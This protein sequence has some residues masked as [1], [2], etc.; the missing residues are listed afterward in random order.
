MVYTRIRLVVGAL[1]FR[2]RSPATTSSERHAYVARRDEPRTIILT[3]LIVSA[4]FTVA[5][6]IIWSV[7]SLFLLGAGLT[8]FQM[9]IVNTGFTLGDLIFQIPTGV[10]ADTLGRKV[11]FMLSIAT[12][13][14]S[15]LL[16][17]A[18]AQYRWGMGAFI[19]AS[20]FIGL[21]FTFYSGA[22]EAWLVDA[23]DRAR[24][25]RPKEQVFAWG[26]MVF[27]GAMVVGSL[28]GG[29]L[30]QIDLRLPYLVR[31]GA[32]AATFIIVAFLMD[33]SAFVRKALTPSAFAE[34]TRRILGR[35]VRVGWHSK[36]VR[37]LL[38][39]SMVQGFFYIFGFYSWQPYFLSLLGRREVWLVGVLASAFGLAGVLGNLLVKPLTAGGRRDP[40]KVLA[41]VAI[42]QSVTI[43]SIGL[44]G[45]LPGAKGGGWLPFAGA[46]SLYLV[47]GVSFGLIR[48]I[49]QGFV[50]RYIPSDA[51]AT[52][53]SANWLFSDAGES[54][55]Q[56]VLG[57]V[58]Q[59]VSIPVAW[60]IGGF[61]LLGSPALYLRA[62]RG[63]AEETPIGEPSEEL[64]P[65][66]TPAC[67]E[68]PQPGA[69]SRAGCSE[70][71]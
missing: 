54:L 32:L 37:P 71:E 4:L 21:G 26:G 61:A 20:I 2:V 44:I 24:Y 12:L 9:F 1:G 6:S 43:G 58:S 17:V 67:G 10:I 53:L 49:Q 14:V 55:G 41:A 33:D 40:A 28:I 3:Y 48:P 34:E 70:V 59:V 23:L 56:P 15:T 46:A 11:S 16:Y 66:T 8:L 62:G 60:V 25:T 63:Q 57:Y 64:L 7:N 36:V 69:S 31:A 29:L 30:G 65:Q 19:G 50:N 52:I 22:V 51:R 68:A 5:T 42:A 39:V 47:F 45:L 27:S 35:G 18:A 38:F 13:V